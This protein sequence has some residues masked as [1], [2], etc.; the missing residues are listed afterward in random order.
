MRRIIY[1][2]EYHIIKISNEINAQKKSYWLTAFY[3]NPLNM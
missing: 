2:N 3:Y 1:E